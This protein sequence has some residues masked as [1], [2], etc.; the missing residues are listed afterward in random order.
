MIG[1]VRTGREAAALG[2]DLACAFMAEGGEGVYFQNGWE[3]PVITADS[4]ELQRATHGFYP[5]QAGYTTVCGGRGPAFAAGAR[6]ASMTLA[7]EGATLAAAM[8][9]KFS[10]ADGKIRKNLLSISGN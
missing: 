4:G 3:A 1:E 9:L 2:A 7:D 10:R 5:D 8:G 6:E